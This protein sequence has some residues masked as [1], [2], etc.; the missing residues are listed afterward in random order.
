MYSR[1]LVPFSNSLS[2][3]LYT[4]RLLTA[5]WDSPNKGFFSDHKIMISLSAGHPRS[6]G[7]WASLQQPSIDDGWGVG[8]SIPQLPHPLGG[9]TLEHVPQ[10]SRVPLQA[11]APAAH[12]GNW[13]DSAPFVSSN[14]FLSCF[15]TPLSAFPGI[16]TQTIDL[17]QNPCCRICFWGIQT[18]ARGY[19]LG[20]NRAFKVSLKFFLIWQLNFYLTLA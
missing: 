8:G 20:G 6:A 2:I 10:C 1:A 17:W 9:T 15:S 4:Q 16:T 11:Q 13:L 19:Q 14:L 7:K 5:N 12:N 18:K 3:Y